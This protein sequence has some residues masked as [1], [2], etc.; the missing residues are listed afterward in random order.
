M[1]VMSSFAWSIG[2]CFILIYTNCQ[3]LM[4]EVNGCSHPHVKIPAENISM[5]NI[6]DKEMLHPNI[7]FAT[8]LYYF[9]QLRESEVL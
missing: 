6:Y 3:V 2:G 7:A 8:F 1:Y 5:G 4:D 9:V